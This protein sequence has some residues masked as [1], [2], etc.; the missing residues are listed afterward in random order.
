[1]DWISLSSLDQQLGKLTRSMH[2]FGLKVKKMAIKSQEHAARVMMTRQPAQGNRGTRRR[3]FFRYTLYFLGT[4]R[5]S[6]VLFMGSTF[7]GAY[8]V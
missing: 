7:L 5:V 6:S 8:R 2:F 1:M 3:G 4:Y